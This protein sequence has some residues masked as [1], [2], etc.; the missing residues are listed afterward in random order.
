MSHFLTLREIG[1]ISAK[2]AEIKSGE[3]ANRAGTHLAFCTHKPGQFCLSEQMVEP[4][5]CHPG[6]PHHLEG[7]PQL[8]LPQA[9]MRKETVG[10]WW[11]Q[12]PEFWAD[13]GC[14]AV[15]PVPL[16]SSKGAAA[17][18]Q[19]SGPTVHRAWRVC[20]SRIPLGGV[21]HSK[22]RHLSK[23]GIA[24]GPA[25]LRKPIS[26]E[27]GT[28]RGQGGVTDLS[29]SAFLHLQLSEPT[30]CQP[31]ISNPLLQSTWPQA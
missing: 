20:P 9:M 3:S 5:L 6:P 26:G 10:Y 29:S 2:G 31:P 4:V 1:A 11:P 30:V 17:S 23:A 14:P 13:H 22:R 18:A 27:A 24:T 16:L 12:C 21:S 19:A 15:S 8:S 7:A 28:G 25:P